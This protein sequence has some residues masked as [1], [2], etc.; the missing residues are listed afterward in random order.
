MIDLISEA[1]GGRIVGFNDEFFAP[2]ENLLKVAEPVWKEDLYIDTGKWMDGWETRRRRDEGHDWCEIALGIPGRIRRVTVDTAFFT[3][4]YPEEFSLE[5]SGDGETWSEVI[6]R[7]G[8]EGDSKASFD[9]DFHHRVTHVRLC[10]F[11]D[12]GV[13]R[14]RVEGDPIPA[15]QE[16]CPGG[17]VDLASAVVGGR[18]LEASDYHYSPPSNLLLPSESAGMWDGWETRRRRGPGHDWATFELGL[19]GVVSGLVVD[20]TH[21]K[22]NSPGW[23]SF[24]VSDDGEA[25]S[26]IV[27][28]TPVEK[29]AINEIEMEESHA[30]FVRLSIHPD[31]GLARMRVLG[32]ADQ[33]AAGAKR[34]EY[35][36][37]LLDSEAR[38]FFGAAC[39]SG[40]WVE[41]MLASRSFSSFDDVLSSA[42]KAFEGLGEADWLEAFAG[43][44]RIGEKGDAVESSEQSGSAG[45]E[46]EL[47]AVNAEYEAKFDFIYIVY[48]S[49]K[50]GEEMLEIARSR[51][52]NERSAEIAV[53]AGEQRKITETR[54]RRMM[55]QETG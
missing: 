18:F 39:A 53:A 12:G 44:P 31:G 41:S 45:F 11:P 7:T 48:A 19:P 23:V 14:L 25:W 27:D 6:A 30:R 33:D 32:L 49:G 16:V 40:R 55:C 24:D 29:H 2:A 34:L 13:A 43:H 4:N 5:V 52:D 22:G 36:N 50:T 20:T 28:R 47:A 9:V 21:F 3:G 8:L 37:C 1:A 35:L 51:L 46:S 42:G 26:T 15:M 17:P 10:I 38:R 54:L